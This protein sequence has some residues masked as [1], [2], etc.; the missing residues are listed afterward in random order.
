VLPSPGWQTGSKEVLGV[1]Q[2]RHRKLFEVEASGGKGCADTRIDDADRVDGVQPGGV[3]QSS[4]KA[5][6]EVFKYG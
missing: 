2:V 4:G 1:G 5:V 3:S 6:V